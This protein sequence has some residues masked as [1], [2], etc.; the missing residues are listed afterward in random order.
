MQGV[1]RSRKG[2]VKKV[3]FRTRVFEEFVQVLRERGIKQV[4]IFVKKTYNPRRTREIIRL[5]ASGDSVEY[6][7]TRLEA[8]VIRADFVEQR[9]QK[10]LSETK[11]TLLDRLVEEGFEVVEGIA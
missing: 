3:A 6:V 7:A 9:I 11:R 10:E 5:I 8:S 2:S 4:Q 1:V